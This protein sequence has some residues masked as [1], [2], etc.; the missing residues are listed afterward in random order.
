[1]PIDKNKEKMDEYHNFR[2]FVKKMLITVNEA[3]FVYNK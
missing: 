2:A 1:M 3:F